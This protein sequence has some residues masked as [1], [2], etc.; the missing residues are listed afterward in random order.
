MKKLS[1]VSG[2]LATMS[3][4]LEPSVTTSS[5]FFIAIGI[6]EVIGSTPSTSTSDNCSTKAEDGVE[7]AFHARGFVIGDRNAGQ[8]RNAFDGGKVYG[9]RVLIG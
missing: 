9:H 8:V 5:R 4:A 7:F 1:V 6:T 2:A 3:S